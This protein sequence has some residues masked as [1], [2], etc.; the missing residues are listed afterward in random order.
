[1]MSEDDTDNK[2]RGEEDLVDEILR[3]KD[4]NTVSA[5][6]V[7]SKKTNQHS[8]NN[9]V[10]NTKQKA[11]TN[12]TSNPL[13]LVQEAARKFGLTVLSSE[14]EKIRYSGNHLISLD[15]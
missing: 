8:N 15:N 12:T 6:E 10:N 11:V 1:M 14:L 4:P 9:K 13:R 3:L 7:Y 2:N 5:F